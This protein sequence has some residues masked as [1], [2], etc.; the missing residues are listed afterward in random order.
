MAGGP[1]DQGG[2]GGVPPRPTLRIRL[3]KRGPP[4][5]LSL[6]YSLLSAQVNCVQDFQFCGAEKFVALPLH[7]GVRFLSDRPAQKAALGTKAAGRP[8][9]ADGP[10]PAMVIAPVAGMLPPRTAHH[11]RSTQRRAS[12]RSG[13]PHS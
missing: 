4:D 6:S 13:Q 1:S 7:D 11:S 12:S 3:L 10:T 5:K 2:A 9:A 8:I